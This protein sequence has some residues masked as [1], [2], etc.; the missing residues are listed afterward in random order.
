MKKS[1]VDLLYGGAIKAQVDWLRSITTAVV[2]VLFIGFAGV[3]VATGAFM[4][5]AFKNKH[6]SY[7]D[8]ENEIRVQNDKIEVLTQTINNL[9]EAQRR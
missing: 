8:L 6:D 9:N 5:D 3:F 7:S 2:A 1:E 4:I